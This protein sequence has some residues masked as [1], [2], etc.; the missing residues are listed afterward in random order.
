MSH[1][2]NLDGNLAAL[3]KHLAKHEPWECRWC[4]EG[5]DDCECDDEYEQAKNDACAEDAWEARN[6]D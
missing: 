2:K 6:E 4:K 1:R 5:R 3:E